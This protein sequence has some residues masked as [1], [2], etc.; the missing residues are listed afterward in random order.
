MALVMEDEGVARGSELE[1]AAAELDAVRRF[2]FRGQPERELCRLG[3]RFHRRH[4]EAHQ[5]AST[6]R[7]REHEV[8]QLVVERKT[9]REI[10]AELFL[11][12]KTVET[13]LRHIFGKLGVSSR[14]AVARALA[15]T[16][17]ERTGKP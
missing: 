4:G 16:G 17:A 7:A 6:L 2:P 3:R 12:E 5:G 15:G 8:A 9:N 10:A 13:H 1:V 14:G 11:S